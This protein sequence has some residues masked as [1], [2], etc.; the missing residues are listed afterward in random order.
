MP[1]HLFHVAAGQLDVRVRGTLEWL[2]PAPLQFSFWA[3]EKGSKPPALSFLTLSESWNWLDWK[4]H[5]F[6][7][8][9]WIFNCFL[10]SSNA[11]LL[12][13]SAL[14]C[15]SVSLFPAHALKPGCTSKML[16][17]SLTAKKSSFTGTARSAVS[18]GICLA[19]VLYSE[20]FNHMLKH[21]PELMLKDGANG[22]ATPPS[23]LDKWFY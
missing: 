9:I 4:A 13:S 12:C 19:L 7:P 22:Y 23:A 20:D 8:V 6:Y 21:F 16:I 17:L 11:I 10:P 5:T 2:F 1:H 14:L 18:L 15:L 3:L